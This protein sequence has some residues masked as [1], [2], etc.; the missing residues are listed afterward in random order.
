[1]KLERVIIFFH[2]LAPSQSLNKHVFIDEL[3]HYTKHINTYI[4][5]ETDYPGDHIT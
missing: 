2:H 1:M 5:N 4:F 3:N